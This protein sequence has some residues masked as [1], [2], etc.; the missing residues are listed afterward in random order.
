M[1]EIK[2]H[3]DLAVPSEDCRRS[4][5]EFSNRKMAQASGTIQKNRSWRRM[6]NAGASLNPK[7]GFIGISE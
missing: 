5:E 6:V 4:S 7:E 2:D 3:K 1:V